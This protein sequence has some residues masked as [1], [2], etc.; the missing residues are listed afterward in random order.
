MHS[1]IIDL[2]P[3]FRCCVGGDVGTSSLAQ[4]GSLPVI[5]VTATLAGFG[6]IGSADAPIVT[7][8]EAD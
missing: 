1:K 6:L 4:N 7:A 8:V 3:D 5:W 2:G